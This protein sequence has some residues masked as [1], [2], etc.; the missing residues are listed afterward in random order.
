VSVVC[1]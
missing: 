1:L